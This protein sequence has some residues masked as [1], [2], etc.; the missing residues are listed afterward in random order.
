MIKEAEQSNDV[1]KMKSGGLAKRGYGR[2][3]R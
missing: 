3:K 1:I 2:A